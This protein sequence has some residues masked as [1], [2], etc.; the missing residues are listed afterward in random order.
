MSPLVVNGD[1]APPPAPAATNAPRPFNTSPALPDN[2][3]K[4][5]CLPAVALLAVTSV[6]ARSVPF[7][8]VQLPTPA[9][10][11]VHH[12][13]AAQ[14]PVGGVKSQDVKFAG[15]FI[16][17]SPAVV[18]CRPKYDVPVPRCNVSVPATVWLTDCIEPSLAM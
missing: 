9:V 14:G 3:G 2:F 17:H 11:V 16:L 5:P 15:G 8:C 4:N 18:P 13:E 10:S 7:G 1:V 6:S 12:C